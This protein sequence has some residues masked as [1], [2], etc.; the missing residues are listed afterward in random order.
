MR[1]LVARLLS[2]LLPLLL[3]ATTGFASTIR[4]TTWNLQPGATASGTEPDARIAKDAAELLTKLGPDIILLQG[5][6]GRALC[7]QIALA[8]KP[9]DYN[10]LICSSFLTVSIPASNPLQVAILS[11]HQASFSWSE[12]WQSLGELRLPGGFAF[13]ALQIGDKRMGIF[14]PKWDNNCLLLPLSN[15]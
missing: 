8:L 4:V 2:G 12:P 11:K 7:D 5:V 10:V 9:A 14:S 3:L 13:A 6:S 1:S 15:S